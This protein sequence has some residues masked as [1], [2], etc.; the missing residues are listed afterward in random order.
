L[1]NLNLIVPVPPSAQRAVQPVITIANGI[2]AKLQLPVRQCITTTRP[3]AQL[4]GVTDP[5]ARQALLD[6]LYAVD[7]THTAG[8]SILLF[9]DLFR[10]GSTMNAITNVLLNDG[11]ASAVYA[12]TITKTR[13][14]R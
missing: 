4:K 14:N 11:K 6:G 5:D 2:G 3:T 8:K 9:D 12:L 7:A 13:S 1:R 10:S